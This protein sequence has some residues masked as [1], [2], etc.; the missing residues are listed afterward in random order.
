MADAVDVVVE[1]ASALLGFRR[2]DEAHAVVTA[3]IAATPDDVRLWEL[4]TQV[5]LTRRHDESARSA[6]ERTLSLDPEHGNALY[7]LASA[8]FRLGALQESQRTAD[9]LLAARPAWAGAHLQWA[10]THIRWAT[11]RRTAYD[12]K[13]F[14]V[15]DEPR[16][17]A[18][19]D[20]ALE[21]Q[22]HDAQLL[23]DAARC[24]HALG[25]TRPAVRQQAR[26]AMDRA[27]EAA[28]N[29]TQV[30]LAAA[31]IARPSERV[32]WNLRVLA[33]DPRSPEALARVEEAVW[34]QV[35]AGPA[36]VAIFAALTTLAA[37]LG[38]GEQASAVARLLG[39]VA[40]VAAAAWVLVLEP[41]SFQRFPRQLLART[42]RRDPQVA[43]A[44]AVSALVWAATTVCAVLLHTGLAPSG[45]DGSPAVAGVLETAL[46]LQVLAAC[47]I[48][49]SRA[50]AAVRSG[51]WSD[52]E[53]TRVR[54]GRH[55]P[56]AANG[57]L[58]AIAALFAWGLTAFVPRGSGTAGAA[59]LPASLAVWVAGFAV[60]SEVA[61]R[62][63]RK[64]PVRLV[65]YALLG[66]GF[67][68]LAVRA[69]LAQLLVA[70]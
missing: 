40:T 66:A 31:T 26:A 18:A 24:Y 4:L 42:L 67:L 14:P 28:P 17:I 9:R 30:I 57:V 52:P 20:R 2:P 45:T 32:R 29:D 55:N 46:L 63:L 13:L 5:E 61:Q 56:W 39:W 6:A 48:T 27:L 25:R 47:T 19:L 34:F 65:A 23:A 35:G 62:V 22:P 68:T 49:V 15:A 10:W 43:V 50:R 70:G 38:A 41:V 11:G 53:V 58:V 1:R 7:A 37:V 16:A 60:A 12:D 44:L 3:A 8:Q 36:V 51:R 59:V 21:L 33:L 54:L 69:L 64:R